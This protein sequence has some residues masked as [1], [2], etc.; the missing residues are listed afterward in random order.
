MSVLIAAAGLSRPFVTY[1]NAPT[2]V[3]GTASASTHQGTTDL[4][5]V[6]PAGHDTNDLILLFC[7]SANEAF[8][9]PSGCFAVGD[10]GVNSGL[11]GARI[12]VFGKWAAS[13][14]EGNITVVNPGDHAGCNVQIARGVSRTNPVNAVNGDTLDS[15]SVNVTIP[16][17]T[18]T[19]P[20]CL[21][22]FAATVAADAGTGTT[23]WL[24][25]TSGGGLTVTNRCNRTYT[26]G[27]GGGIGIWTAT[28][29][30][31]GATGNLAGT[32]NAGWSSRQARI[33]FALTPAS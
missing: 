11:D 33:A 13:N 30:T 5:V 10:Y 16:S 22:F 23:N 20:N 6:V 18:T 19:V 1:N 15:N 7:E 2:Y 4:T 14:A 25:F 29:T 24:T 28:K 17:V 3:T 21:I 32:V 27:N 26:G 9:T 31:A 12:Q 8:A